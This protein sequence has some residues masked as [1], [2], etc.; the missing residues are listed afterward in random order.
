MC[1]LLYIVYIPVQQSCAILLCCAAVVHLS[2]L[3]AVAFLL[4]AYNY[5]LQ[6]FAYVYV[7]NGL[8]FS[9]FF[10]CCDIVTYSTV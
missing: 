2:L 3:G 7:T 1:P 8:L 10:R 4:A 5:L 9:F 6:F